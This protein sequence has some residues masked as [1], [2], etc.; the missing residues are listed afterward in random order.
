MDFKKP[1]VVQHVWLESFKTAMFS[2]GQQNRK[3]WYYLSLTKGTVRTLTG[4]LSLWSESRMSLQFVT[5]ISHS[6]FYFFFT[7]RHTSILVF[8]FTRGCLSHEHLL[9]FF[10][11]LFG[12]LKLKSFFCKLSL[13]KKHNNN[14][15]SKKKNSLLACITAKKKK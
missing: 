1:N 15:N 6:V 2:T 4:M 3:P 13:I 10:C 9:V 8:I 12:L 5:A 11:N 14:N 7:Y